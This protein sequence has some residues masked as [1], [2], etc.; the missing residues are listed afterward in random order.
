MLALRSDIQEQALAEFSQ[1]SAYRPKVVGTNGNGGSS[2]QRRVPA[3]IPA[4]PAIVL[5]PS[6]RVD[7]RN[8]DELR[9]RLSN[10]QSGTSR[11]R[12]ESVASDDEAVAPDDAAVAPDGPPA[13]ISSPTLSD[14]HQEEE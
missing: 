3:V 6:E 4:A 8:P 2:L 7:A 1:L 9:S 12:R 11:G 10:F 14:V 13:D 5:A